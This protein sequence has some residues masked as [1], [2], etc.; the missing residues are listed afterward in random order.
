MKRAISIVAVLC[1][2]LLVAG[3]DLENLADSSRYREDFSYT[4][5]LKAGGRVT[6]ENFNGSVEVLGWEKDAVQITGTKYAPTK[7]VLQGLKIEA[8]AKDD[9]LVIRTVRP[10]GRRD[11]VGAK[12][13]L[14]VPAKVVLD[15]IAT[16]NGSVRIED[17]QGSAHVQTSNGSVQ[18]QRIAGPLEIRT[19]N[20][21]IDVRG[22]TGDADLDSS[23]GS[24]HVDEVAGKVKAS[25]SNA[26]IH[27]N[28]AKPAPQQPLVLS[29]TNGSIE[30]GLDSYN[31]NAVRASTNNAS[32]TLRLPAGANADLR[33]HTS[34]ASIENRL[35]MKWI[36]S[37]SKNRLEGVI[38]SGGPLIDLGT[39]NGSIRLMSR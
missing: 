37:S 6:V 19:S 29:T 12:Y 13:V 1:L 2:M 8:V 30:I 33:A 24:I 9:S 18:T 22:V 23:N 38:G 31:G 27:V 28:M 15:R 17:I 26:S 5:P 14:R 35:E 32:I 25:T 36:G 10:D 7:E 3:C 39:S 20:A 11:G 16:S 4:Y 34:N 21:R